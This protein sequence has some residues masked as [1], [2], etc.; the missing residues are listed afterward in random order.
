MRHSL[1]DGKCYR[2]GMRYLVSLVSYRWFGSGNWHVDSGSHYFPNSVSSFLE[3][4]NEGMA[5]YFYL[6]S[7]KKHEEERLKWQKEKA[8]YI[9]KHIH[10]YDDGH[11]EFTMIKDKEN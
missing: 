7:L 5:F 4:G 10:A 8:Y 9:S 11:E 6:K 2:S 3:K 1:F